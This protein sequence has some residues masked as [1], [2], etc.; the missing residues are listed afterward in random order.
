MASLAKLVLQITTDTTK[1][2]QGFRQAQQHIK[3]FDSGTQSA[4]QSLG[5]LVAAGGAFAVGIGSALKILKEIEKGFQLATNEASKLQ[6]RMVA[7]G[8]IGAD[9]TFTAQWQAFGETLG[10]IALPAVQSITKEL[11]AV[12]EDLAHLSG[13]DKFLDSLKEAEAA[14]KRVAD[15]AKKEEDRRNAI[16]QSVQEQAKEFDRLNDRARQLRDSLRTPAELLE[17]GQREIGKLLSENLV[18]METAERQA[19]KL[20]KDFQDATRQAEKATAAQLHNPGLEKGSVAEVQSRIEAAA[21]AKQQLEIERRQKEAQDETNRLI[22]Q[23]L[24][25]VRGQQQLVLNRGIIRGY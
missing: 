12:N 19:A 15:E 1:M 23:L 22:T 10:T 2:V 4:G 17:A 8:T 3:D 13:A 9:E 20:V 24:D 5:G 6:E 16:R 25:A 18:S 14:Q 11:R 7:L 21:V